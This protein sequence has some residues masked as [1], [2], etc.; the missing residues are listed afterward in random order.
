M[1]NDTKELNAELLTDETK[2]LV[3]S[4]TEIDK[5]YKDKLSQFYSDHSS[6]LEKLEHLRMQRNKAL[7]DAKQSLR[8]DAASHSYDDAKARIKFGP[9]IVQKKWTSWYVTEMFVGLVK[10]MGLYK[11]AVE[12][13]VI[14][15]KTE[16]N[17]KQAEEWLRKNSL[18]KKFEAC[19]DGKELT[20]AITGPKPVVAMGAEEK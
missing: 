6:E 15:V 18:T 5:E 11:S 16:I 20:P 8:S 1:N 7:D 4:F 17:S 13:G 2:T 19:E 9:F 12:H 10:S 3:D 14:E